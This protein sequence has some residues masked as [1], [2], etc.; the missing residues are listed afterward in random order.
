M[1][2]YQKQPFDYMSQFFRPSA[3][4]SKPSFGSLNT[5]SDGYSRVGPYKYK[6]S[7]LIGKGFSSQVYKGYHQDDPTKPYAI[8]AINLKKFKAS[9]L[10]LL[11]NE[12]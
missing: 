12:I 1:R 3:H 11:E 2:D 10:K 4:E 5:I 6:E 9:S 8:K 7:S